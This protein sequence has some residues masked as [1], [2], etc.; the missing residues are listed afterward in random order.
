MFECMHIQRD[1]SSAHRPCRANLSHLAKQVTKLSIH[2]N[3]FGKVRK[4][5]RAR[6]MSR[7]VMQSLYVQSSYLSSN[8]SRNVYTSPRTI[9]FFAGEPI[10]KYTCSRWSK[11]GRLHANMATVFCNGCAQSIFSMTQ[12]HC[13]FLCQVSRGSKPTHYVVV[14]QCRCSHFNTDA[15]Y[16]E[17]SR[18]CGGHSRPCHGPAS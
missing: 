2:C 4:V 15:G 5:H 3:L 10:H 18:C 6:A 7:A 8:P 14:Q 16:P 17:R 13:F 9:N 12:A 1:D 11:L